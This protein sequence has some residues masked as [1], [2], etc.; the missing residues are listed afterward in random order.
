MSPARQAPF[1]TEK[2]RVA[3]LMRRLGQSVD[4]FENP[5]VND[6]SG[7]DVIAVINGQRIGIQ[8]TDLDTGK[9]RGNARRDESKLAHEAATKGEPYFTWGQND[10]AKLV[11]AIA[12]SV[13]Q[14]A[15]TSS[16]RLSEFWLLICCGVPTQGAVGSTFAMTPWIDV[17]SLGA[18][19]LATLEKSSYTRAFVLPIL[20]AEDEGLFQWRRGGSWSK[21]ADSTRSEEQAEHLWETIRN[22]DPELLRDPGEWFQQTMERAVR[23]AKRSQHE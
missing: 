5:N 9:K 7:A 22:P 11:G 1:E 10:P 23:E 13:E 16:S 6:E 3:L 12:R 15:K 18:A 21:S 20:G 8:V 2:P 14:K 19:T 17:A 4:R